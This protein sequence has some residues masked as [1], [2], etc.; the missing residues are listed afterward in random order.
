MQ[1]FEALMDAQQLWWSNT[2]K[3]VSSAD[4][5]IQLVKQR[6]ANNILEFYTLVN[7]S[8]AERGTVKQNM[9]ADALETSVL[10]LPIS[11][12]SAT[13]DDANCHCC[14]VAVVVVNAKP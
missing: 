14:C 2:A 13:V 3:H 10:R 8:K 1:N 12:A 9:A 11:Q 7:A 6:L 4:T 5:D